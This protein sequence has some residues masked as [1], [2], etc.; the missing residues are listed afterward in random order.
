M[1]HWTTVVTVL[2]W[3]SL[4]EE[5]APPAVFVVVSRRSPMDFD[6]VMGS[7]PFRDVSGACK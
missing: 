4:L 3:G 2:G 7:R 6:V 5:A 1:L